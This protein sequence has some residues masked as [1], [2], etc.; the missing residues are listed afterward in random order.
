MSEENRK[1]EEMQNITEAVDSVQN[2][3]EL[4]ESD[5]KIVETGTDDNLT[6]EIPKTTDAQLY[7]QNKETDHDEIV[8]L[9]AASE[10]ELADLKLRKSLMEANFDELLTEYR[11]LIIPQVEISTI[12]KKILLEYFSYELLKPLHSVGLKP[13]ESNYDVWET[14][15]F[16]VQYYLDESQKLIFNFKINPVD[17]RF[18]S[19][20]MPLMVIDIEQMKITVNDD[21]VLALIHL[22]Y[23]DK[24]F[25]KN[26]LSL[27]NYDINLLLQHFR[28]LGFDVAATL[29]DN[30]Q[31]LHVKLTTDYQMATPVLDEIF[32]ITMEN[33][34][35]DFEKNKDNH[36]EVLLD[37]EQKVAI[38]PDDDDQTALFIDS[39]NRRRSLLDFFT[40]YA[41]LV[42]LLVRK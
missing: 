10:K 11:R 31:E 13:A 36:Y 3:S 35:Y 34:E 21:E 12:A 2:P 39:N 26:Q 18:T 8:L 27:V 7:L 25:S 42:P 19:E 28:E 29:L 17:Q 40:S 33:E 24:V 5:S 20:F 23:A 1:N 41:F 16:L 37:Q 15:H 14:K 22:W 9:I 4:S 38:Y 6:T 30:T 32:I